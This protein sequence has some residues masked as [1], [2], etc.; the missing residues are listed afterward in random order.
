[1]KKI[2]KSIRRFSRRAKGVHEFEF[3]IRDIPIVIP[4]PILKTENV[5]VGS[6]L[7]LKLRIYLRNLI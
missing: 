6:K 4:Y 5:N 1:M 3:D 7:F 2:I